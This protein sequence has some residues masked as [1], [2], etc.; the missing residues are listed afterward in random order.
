MTLL[1]ISVFAVFSALVNAQDEAV[2][3]LLCRRGLAG[4]FGLAAACCTARC[5][6]CGGPGC[7][8]R[9]GGGRECCGSVINTRNRPC[10]SVGPPCIIQ[11]DPNC[12]TGL[13]NRRLG[14]CCASECGQCGGV[15]GDGCE[16][17]FNVPAG[18]S[19]AGRCCTA[20]IEIANRSCSDFP[21]PCTLAPRQPDPQCTQGIRNGN[22]CCQRR[23]GTCGGRGCGQR[24]GGGNNCCLSRIQDPRRARSCALNEAPCLL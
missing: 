4:P 16:G 10:D 5:G 20:E 11:S 14:L 18:V 22:I 17:R 2:P 21:P 6:N 19:T 3:D 15:N 23:C 12:E 9:P 1:L 24:P 8:S 13:R 7:G